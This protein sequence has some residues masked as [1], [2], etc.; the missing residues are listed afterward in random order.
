MVPRREEEALPINGR[1][2]SNH[3]SIKIDADRQIC[4]LKARCSWRNES[5]GGVFWFFY[6][7]IAAVLY[8]RPQVVY[9]SNIL[10]H[11]FR[12]PAD[13]NPRGIFSYI[14]YHINLIQF[15]NY[16]LERNFMF[17]Y[18]KLITISVEVRCKE[19]DG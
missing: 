14:P 2:L 16:A 10:R 17:S 19:Y 4:G 11:L 12:A 1:F 13:W 5:T 8:G 3:V 6:S 9:S 7:F 18:R 15:K